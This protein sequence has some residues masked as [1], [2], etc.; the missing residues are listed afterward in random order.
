M[1]RHQHLH[2]PHHSRRLVTAVAGGCVLLVLGAAPALA[3]WQGSS[4]RTAQ[5]GMARFTTA[6]TKASGDGAVNA[7]GTYTLN[8]LL[9]PQT[10]YVT[11]TNTSTA[12]AL[13][14]VTYALSSLVAGNTISLCPQPWST[15]GTCPSAT[16]LAGSQVLGG[17]SGFYS[18]PTALAPQAELYMRVATAGVAGGATVSATAAPART[19]GDRTLG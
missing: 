16:T 1:L 15:G 11:V 3:A 12:P 14:T 17:A 2:R 18:S 4:T 5:V 8:G 19:A 7:S 9:A 13:V 6:L 10:G